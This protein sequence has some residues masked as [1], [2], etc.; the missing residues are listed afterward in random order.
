MGFAYKQWL[1]PFYPAGMS[2][3]Q[4]LRHY[5]GRFDAVE[6][7]STFYGAPRPVQVQRWAQ[8]TPAKFRF[9]L[10]TP[11]AITHD[12]P[13]AHGI[14]AMGQ[15]LEV[16]RLLENKLGVILLQFSPTFTITEIEMLA[17]FLRQLPA[18][19]RYA[20]EFRH[21]SWLRLETAAMLRQQRICWVAA[22]YIH[23]PPAIQRTTDFLY[24]R[25]IGK[26]GQYVTKDREMVD[27]TTVL[28]TWQERIT[29]HLAEV[30]DIYGFFNNDFSGYSPATCNCFK[31]IVG[32]E[33]NDIHAL[34]QGR[35]F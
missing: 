1:G 24:L 11:R 30:G 9:C 6:I 27:K 12:A 16:A 25:F 14:G 5:S 34:Q 21:T 32:Q 35:L 31:R 17:D 8:S 4:F 13:L 19:S 33:L 22:D 18:T 15:F 29:P 20:I 7:D 23:L 2:A 26:H 28:R 3:R 10:K